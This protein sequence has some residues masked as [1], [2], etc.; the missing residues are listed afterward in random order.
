MNH[1]L[2]ELSEAITKLS[3]VPKDA[4]IIIQQLGHNF[5]L[6]SAKYNYLKKNF[7]D[8]MNFIEGMQNLSGKYE[9]FCY[10]IFLQFILQIISHSLS[11]DFLF[12][13]ILAVKQ[14]EKTVSLQIPK[15]T[16]GQNIFKGIQTFLNN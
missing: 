6:I 14:K 11:L 2:E 7:Q 5:G 16:D 10:N 1:C 8:F 9:N 15:E 13:L 12:C 3:I 4:F